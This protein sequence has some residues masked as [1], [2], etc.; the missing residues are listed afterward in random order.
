MKNNKITLLL[1]IL[2]NSD[3]VL[4]ACGCTSMTVQRVGAATICSNNDVQFN[5]CNRVAGGQGTACPNNTY[6]FTCPTGVNDQHWADQAPFQR[7]GFKVSATYAGGS[8]AAECITGQILQE[9]ITSNG[10]FEG[11]PLINPSA[12]GGNETIGGLDLRINNNGAQ[13][14]P[15]VGTTYGQTGRQFYGGDNYAVGTADVIYN[16]TNAGAQWWDNT[17][18]TKDMQG[19][20]ATWSYQFISYV[21]GTAGQPSCSCSTTISVNWLANSNPVTMMNGGAFANENCP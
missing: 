14:V 11:N 1:I 3:M 21:R 7:T 10:V 6:V 19:E 20:N 5:E 12:L 8:N 16:N 15:R 13:S 4:A 2:M 9:T 18:Q 17:D